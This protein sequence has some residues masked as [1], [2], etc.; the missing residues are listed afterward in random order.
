M[1]AGRRLIVTADD[2][3]R[4]E[5][6]NEAVE[7]GHR[8]GILTAAS[9]M[10]TGTAA[11]DAVARARRL[12]GLGV[13]LHVALVD[14]LPVLPPERIPDLVDGEGRF[15]KDLGRLGARIYLFPRVRTQV[16]AE[17]RAQFDL[18]RRTGLPLDHVDSHHHYHLHPTVFAL[19]IPLARAYGAK[20]LR[21]PF[22]PPLASLR[23]GGTQGWARLGTA[24]FHGRRALRMRRQAR[25]QGLA[26]ND[27]LFGQFDSGAMDRARMAAYIRALPPGLNELYCHPGAC[28][29]TEDHPMPARY[30]P[31]DEF[32][33]LIAPELRACVEAGA[34]TLTT[35]SRERT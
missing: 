26:T 9:L 35:F 5:A 30:R 20:G 31:V 15:T 10:V 2:F 19:L 14:A 8:E 17:M 4:A 12:P 32:Q 24:L 29:W 3:G 6:I 13:G 23:G 18:F 1:T 22:E 33:A 28:A 11:A 27:A 7:R 34:I 21:I 25:R 16:A